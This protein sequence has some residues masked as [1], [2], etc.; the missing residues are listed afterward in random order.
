M[1]VTAIVQY[2]VFWFPDSKSS[3]AYSKDTQKNEAT[4]KKPPINPRT[5]FCMANLYS[6]FSRTPTVDVKK[7]TIL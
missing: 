1:Q 6:W 4:S 2:Q 3:S 5:N 7:P